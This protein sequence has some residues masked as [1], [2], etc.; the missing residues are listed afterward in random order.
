MSGIYNTFF[1]KPLYNTLIAIFETFPWADAGV[2]VIMLTIIVRFIL[3]P[4]TKK[5][6]KTQVYMQRINPELLKIKEKY[7]NNKEEEARQ[8][9][10]LYREK[11]VNPFSGIFV[12]L[13]QLPIIWALYQIFLHAG[14]PS[15][16]TNILYSFVRVPENINILFLG[17]MDITGQSFI[18]ALLA[19]ISSYFQIKVSVGSQPKP[20][21]TTF[22][23]NLTRSMQ[24]QLKY[25]LPVIVFFI[26]WKISGVIALY[27]FTT[28]I[29][30]IIQEIVVRKKLETSLA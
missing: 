27:W 23:D 13:L 7:K 8:T 25:F 19:A 9:L 12:L 28:N 16:N 20:T 10:A 6:I 21:G 5:A 22:A 4:L 29:F 3:Y 30:T 2:A 11:G 14:F 15:V 24:T 17:V 18:L 1:Y 26:S